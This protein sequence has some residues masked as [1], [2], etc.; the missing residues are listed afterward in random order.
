MDSS[1]NL[2]FY[3]LFPLSLL[4]PFLQVIQ[5][6]FRIPPDVFVEFVSTLDSTVF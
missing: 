6:F 2:S 3:D 4:L 1:L 5:T